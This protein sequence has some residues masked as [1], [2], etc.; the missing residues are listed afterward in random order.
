MD[1]LFFQREFQYECDICG[2]LTEC[3]HSPCKTAGDVNNYQDSQILGYFMKRQHEWLVMTKTKH[4][5]ILRKPMIVRRI[6][7]KAWDS[8]R[9][10]QIR[11]PRATPLGD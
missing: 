3:W 2:F 6:Y 9:Y 4:Q 1:P 8:C 5:I 10:S 7:T 11:F